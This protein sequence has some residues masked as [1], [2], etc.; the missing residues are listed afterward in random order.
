MFRKI[1]LRNL[2]LAGVLVFAGHIFTAAEAHAQNN[3]GAGVIIGAPTGLSFKYNLNSRNAI[4]A[5]LAWSGSIDFHVHGTYLW[6]KPKLF[7][8]DSYAI[9][10]FYGIGARIREKEHNRFSNEDDD[11]SIGMRGAGGLSFQFRDPRIEIFIEAALIFDVVPD[12][13]A[14]LDAG[15]GAR[16]YF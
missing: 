6:H 16:Y 7:F 9:D 2:F 11:T 15:I 3:F 1:M 8:L 13:D 12:T 5:A 10:G 4:D 14:D